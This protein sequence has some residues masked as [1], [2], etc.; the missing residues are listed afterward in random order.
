MRNANR[1]FLPLVILSLVTGAIG[2]YLGLLSR[3]LIISKAIL[4]ASSIFM[5]HQ[6]GLLYLATLGL[7][8]AAYFMLYGGPTC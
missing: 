7:G 1:L 6:Y 3:P 5:F 2:L 4:F 8:F